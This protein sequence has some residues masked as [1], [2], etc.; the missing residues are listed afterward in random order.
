[1]HIFDPDIELRPRFHRSASFKQQAVE[2]PMDMSRPLTKDEE[3]DLIWRAKYAATSPEPKMSI[4][5]RKKAYM[6]N[7]REDDEDDDDFHHTQKQR[8]YNRL[9][10]EINGIDDDEDEEDYDGVEDDISSLG[11]ESNVHSEANTPYHTSYG[12]S[13]SATRPYSNRLDITV[14]SIPTIPEMTTPESNSSFDRRAVTTTKEISPLPSPKIHKQP[15]SSSSHP[16][17]P[18]T[19]TRNH[20]LV[21]FWKCF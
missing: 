2:S 17:H 3:E 8:N 15:R 16:P 11:L 14:N 10:N 12:L 7:F 4:Q 1:M 20:R 13:Q 5:D 6:D 18:K 19:V 9:A 21:S